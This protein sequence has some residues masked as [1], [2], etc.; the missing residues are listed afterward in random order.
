LVAVPVSHPRSSSR[1]RPFNYAED[2]LKGLIRENWLVEG[3]VL[4]DSAFARAGTPVN[5]EQYGIYHDAVAK[6]YADSRVTHR[7]F[8]PVYVQ[9]NGVTGRVTT[10]RFVVCTA[11]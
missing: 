1:S 2:A 8:V 9:D 5:I 11:G 7:P 4:A 3:E 6:P 10:P